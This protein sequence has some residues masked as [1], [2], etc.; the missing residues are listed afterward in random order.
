MKGVMFTEFL[1][2]V[3]DQFGME[4]ADTVI[5]KGCPF[6]SGGFTAV[7]SYDY[8]SLLSMV[9]QLS[10]QTGAE[11]A[12]LLRQFGRH[13]FS[14]FLESYPDAFD[15]ATSTFDL[16]LRVEE[17][18]HGEVRKLNPDAELPSFRFPATDE[19]CFDVEYESTRPFADLA[20]GLIEACIEHFN[21][22]LEIS[23]EELEG[24]PGTHVL[25]SLRPAV[26]RCPWIAT[27]SS[28]VPTITS[29]DR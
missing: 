28:D 29:S 4:M 18:I 12:A 8:R 6:H 3:E 1:E 2:L 9:D 22:S 11:R 10:Q 24:E 26:K 25:F 23:R 21:E 16:L 19:G 17:V 5:T 7:G 15:R 20:H 27:S 14:K 13:M